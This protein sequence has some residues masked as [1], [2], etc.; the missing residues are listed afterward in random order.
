MTMLQ[1][2][3]LQVLEVYVLLDA[4]VAAFAGRSGLRCPQGCGHCCLTES[5]EAAEFD[6]FELVTDDPSAPMPLFAEAGMRITALHP[7]LGTG[8]LPI[9]AALHQAL[10]KVGMILDLQSGSWRGRFTGSTTVQFSPFFR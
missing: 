3:T 10:Q 9:N 7:G 6:P 4:A 2:L 8:R 1:T 5:V